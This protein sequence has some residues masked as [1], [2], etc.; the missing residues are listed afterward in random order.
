M[1]PPV[2]KQ[3]IQLANQTA[4]M[5]QSFDTVNTLLPELGV[6]GAVT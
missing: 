4:T 2:T 1:S 6:A 5:E 3:V